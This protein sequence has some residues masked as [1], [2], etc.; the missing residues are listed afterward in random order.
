MTRRNRS[1]T[2]GRA[3]LALAVVAICL[4]SH[5]IRAQDT[6]AKVMV[7]VGD[8]VGLK[9]PDER[10]A[11]FDRHV[12]AVN[13]EAASPPQ[14]SAGAPPSAA[15]TDAITPTPTSVY[16]PAAQGTTPATSA[17][18][19]ATASVTAAA[20]AAASSAS[21]ATPAAAAVIA[22][23]PT[24]PAAASSAAPP[25]PSP[26]ATA[27]TGTSPGAARSNPPQRNAEPKPPEIV[28]TVTE[29]HETV[30]NA[31]LITLDNGQV[32]RQ[33]VPQRFALKTGQQVTLRGS[34]WGASYRLSAD[35]LGG[36]IQVEQV[37]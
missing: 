21:T 34:K 3:D 19:A 5:E 17:P 2:I 32:W 15:R 25:A 30:P 12:E 24:A 31:W 11:C 35:T 4:A 33:N 28:A 22:P 18:V 10:L 1:P 36:F 8:C 9:S 13:R 37:R 7:D 23:A 6:P 26:G 20:S 29:L 16:A 14:T 27:Q